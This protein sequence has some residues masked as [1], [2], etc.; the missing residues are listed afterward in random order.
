MMNSV[1][2]E[3]GIMLM[4]MFMKAILKIKREMDK[5]KC[6]IKMEMNT[7]EI[8]TKIKE[9]AKEVRNSLTVKIIQEN[10]KMM[11]SMEKA[12]KKYAN[13]DSY[14][15]NFVAAKREGAGN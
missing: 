6:N 15:G 5:D 3:N 12:K 14:E 4:V 13:G 9:K 10:G 2:K 7:L 8:G 11:K 1:E